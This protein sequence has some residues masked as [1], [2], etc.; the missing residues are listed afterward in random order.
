MLTDVAREERLRQSSV[1]E[2]RAS[3]RGATVSEQGRQLKTRNEVVSPDSPDAG[4]DD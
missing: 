2:C 3:G 1:F 4:T